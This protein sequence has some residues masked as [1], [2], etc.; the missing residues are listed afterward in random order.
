MS[1]RVCV[2]EKNTLGENSF[3]ISLLSLMQIEFLI[4]VSGGFF[5]FFSLQ[6]SAPKV[7]LASDNL[8]KGHEGIVL[9][10]HIASEPPRLC[11]HCL[12]SSINVFLLYM[13][14]K[15]FLL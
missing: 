7:V 14:Q 11:F 8:C 3:Q 5:V 13:S 6:I 12:N 4:T 15:Q 9:G 1:K 2:V 10:T